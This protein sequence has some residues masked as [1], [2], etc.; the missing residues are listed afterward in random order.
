MEEL[1][2][3]AL[4]E[5]AELVY[6]FPRAFQLGDSSSGIPAPC[7]EQTTMLLAAKVK[8]P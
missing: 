2:Q 4:G 6:V 5:R 8:P 7:L 1:A 3:K